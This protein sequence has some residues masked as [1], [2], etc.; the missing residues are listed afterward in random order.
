M[1]KGKPRQSRSP[2]EAR[3]KHEKPS[4]PEAAEARASPSWE[5]TT[6]LVLPI[7]RRLYTRF[8]ASKLKLRLFVEGTPEDRWSDVA[9]GLTDVSIS[10]ISA[11]A[12]RELPAGAKIG[13]RIENAQ[14]AL[15]LGGEVRWCEKLKPHRWRAGIVFSFITARD[16]N[17]LRDWLRSIQYDLR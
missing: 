17:T 14:E 13:I 2:G 7:E 4:G 5:E 12:L 16:L 10:G 11:I 1:R 6:K 15:I 8:K 9:D 3:V